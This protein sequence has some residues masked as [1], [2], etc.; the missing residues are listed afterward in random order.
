MLS[1]EI[2]CVVIYLHRVVKLACRSAPQ[3]K[4]VAWLETLQCKS[5][6]VRQMQRYWEAA[7]YTLQIGSR[8]TMMR[9]VEELF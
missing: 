1:G 2:S 8:S 7:E 5:A 6:G 3:G 4:Q 9:T